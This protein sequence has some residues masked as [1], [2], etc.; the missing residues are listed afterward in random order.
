MANQLTAIFLL[1]SIINLGST[2][3]CYKCRSDVTPN[4]AI[5]PRKDMEIRDCL[6]TDQ[7]VVA[8]VNGI[9]HRNCFST[10]FPNKYCPEK[11]CKTCKTSLCNE[12]IFPNDRLL[13]YQCSG[14][15]ECLN[16][17]KNNLKPLACLEYM[18]KDRCYTNVN[19]KT[20]I[21]RG[22]VSKNS[23]KCTNICLKC[24]YSGCN[25]EKDF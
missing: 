19:S 25:N 4:C 5:N 11:L 9:T 21:E 23:E 17:E 20:N 18:E 2:L 10:L 24:N 22:C 7:C 3:E 15:E 1:A 13:C 6:D 12:E 8:I 16:V 14:G